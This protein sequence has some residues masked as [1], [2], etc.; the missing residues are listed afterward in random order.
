MAWQVIAAMAASTAVTLMG[1]RQ[2]SKVIANNA[3]WER[4]E[5]ELSFQYE[6][7]K[8]LKEQAKLMSKQRAYSGASGATF[9]GSPLINA[10]ADFEEF[11]NDMWY[12]E[13]RFFVQNAASNAELTGLLTA[14]KYKMAGTLLSGASSYSNYK[15]GKKAAGKG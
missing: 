8:Q 12:L 5:N 7:Q 1:Q 3:A 10:N 9:S 2:Q 15:Y 11:E 4:Y 14:Q 13:K 6:K